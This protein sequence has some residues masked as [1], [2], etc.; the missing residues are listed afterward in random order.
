V[1]VE[2]VDFEAGVFQEFERIHRK[3]SRAPE[4]EL[5]VQVEGDIH[6][7]EVEEEDEEE[8]RSDLDGKAE[9]REEEQVGG[10]E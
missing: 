2:M 8:E 7:V 4:Q 1:V 5:E 3:E 6:T 9:L 10:A